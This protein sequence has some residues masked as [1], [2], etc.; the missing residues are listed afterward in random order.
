MKAKLQNQIQALTT[1]LSQLFEALGLLDNFPPTPDQL[2]SL[3]P[4]SNEEIGIVRRGRQKAFSIKMTVDDLRDVASHQLQ[5][6]GNELIGYTNQMSDAAVI[7]TAPANVQAFERDYRLWDDTLFRLLKLQEFSLFSEL[8]VNWKREG[9]SFAEDTYWSHLLRGW[10]FAAKESIGEASSFQAMIPGFPN[11]ADFDQLTFY[12]EADPL[13]SEFDLTAYG[14]D[15]AAQHT[16]PAKP[17]ISHR[18]ID[19]REVRI[20]MPDPIKLMKNTRQTGE[21]WERTGEFIEP[22]ELHSPPPTIPWKLLLER[23]DSVFPSWLF[24]LDASDFISIKRNGAV[25]ESRNRWVSRLLA[26]RDEYTEA[27]PD[28]KRIATT[29]GRLLEGI[30]EDEI[31]D[32][33][34]R[35]ALSPTFW[36]MTEYQAF[37]DPDS[38]KDRR[39]QVKALLISNPGDMK[40]EAKELYESLCVA[41]VQGQY[42]TTMML[43]RACLEISIKQNAPRLNIKLQL[44][45]DYRQGKFKDQTLE[46]LVSDVSKLEAYGDLATAMDNIRTAGNDAIHSS[47]KNAGDH[48]G[49][50]FRCVQNVRLVMERMYASGDC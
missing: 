34:R 38:W 19:P 36:E 17:P 1:E 12:R 20:L 44:P 9:A 23:M 26:A 45:S 39:R 41:Y 37:V 2:C 5:R 22:D 10:L 42:L 33:V 18:R 7:K 4:L 28:F 40:T 11:T 15:S 24:E 3:R 6:Q 13:S 21:F 30:A 46:G 14:I 49:L 29:F 27:I 48:P 47:G 31:P 43:A 50:A 16:A 35:S 8:L 25:H 32:R